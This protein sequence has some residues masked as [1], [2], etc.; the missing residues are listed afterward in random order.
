MDAEVILATVIRDDFKDFPAWHYDSKGLFS[1]K[2]AYRVYVQIR[3]A[4]VLSSS[5]NAEEGLFWR[6]IW[7][8]HVCLR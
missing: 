3:D 8:Y 4:N 1:V 7:I 2:S 6:K 5:K